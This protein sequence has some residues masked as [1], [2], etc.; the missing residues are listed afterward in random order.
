MEEESE[1]EEEEDDEG[2]EKEEDQEEDEED[3]DSEDDI[4]LGSTPQAPPKPSV[5]GGA[6]A[7]L[8]REKRRR[9]AD[10]TSGFSLRKSIETLHQVVSVNRDTL[11]AHAVLGVL[12]F[13][14]VLPSIMCSTSW[15]RGA[16]PSQA[17]DR[18]SGTVAL[19]PRT[20]KKHRIVRTVKSNRRHEE[21]GKRRRGRR[22]REGEDGRRKLM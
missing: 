11:F 12:A 3:E 14:E 10:E 4:F 18:G 22:A 15:R 5:Q 8:R 19:T 1:A 7:P 6:R 2:E 17:S 13:A 16:V 21:S 20:N 9:W